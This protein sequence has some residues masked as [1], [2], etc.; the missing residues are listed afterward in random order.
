MLLAVDIGNSSISI[1]LF[2]GAE[3]YT[4]LRMD[5]VALRSSDH[6]SQEVLARLAESG[7]SLSD[8]GRV[9]VSCVVPRLGAMTVELCRQS[10]R[11]E[12]VIVSAGLNTGLTFSVDDPRKLGADRIVNAV[13]ANHFF[14]APHVVVDMGTATTFDYVNENKVFCGG[15]IAPGLQICGEALTA[16]AALLPAIEAVRPKAFFGK[17]T[18]EA[19][20]AGL[21]YGYVGLVEGILMR[22]SRELSPMPVVV[23]T[24]GL[25]QFIAPECR[26][27]KQICPELTLHGLRLLAELNDQGQE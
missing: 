26:M 5:S 25:A 3:L 2:E 18:E 16:R 9:I 14:G 6:F 7:V 10:L 11:R 15:L 20:A 8:L 13:A 23:A 24:G 12:P 1:G 21:Y 27:V 4:Q 22:M 17:N 19:M